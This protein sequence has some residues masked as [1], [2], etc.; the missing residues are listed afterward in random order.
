MTHNG[1]DVPGYR[2]VR[3]GASDEPVEAL[4]DVAAWTAREAYPKILSAG[5]PVFGIARERE[6][7]GWELHP[8][9]V[10]FQP[11]AARDALAM[12]LRQLATEARERGEHTGAAE[13]ERA[14]GRLDWEPL[15][16]VAVL[17]ERY[18]VVR[19]ERFIRSGPDGPEPPR[20]TDP[21]PAG[22]DDGVRTPDPAAGFVLD[23][24]RPTGMSEGILK[25][26][27]LGLTPVAGAV[28]ADV[29]RDALL[30]TASHPGG[31]LLPVGFMAAE[32]VDGRWEPVPPNHGNTPQQIRESLALGLRVIDPVTRGLDPDERAE[33]A[34]AAERWESERP[35]E[36]EVGGRRLRV[37]RV[38]RLVRFGPDGP[39]SPRPSDPD[40]ELPFLAQEELLCAQ[41]DF[42]RE[43]GDPFDPGEAVLEM[44]RLMREEEERRR[45]RRERG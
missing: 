30:V 37:V 15:N 41:G 22:P 24:V 3:I 33:Y 2:T 45:A 16:E 7:G 14:A 35:V 23:P 21:D 19:G 42:P 32:L 1:E 43:D 44:S 34:E 27:L 10:N 28:P 4:A 26:E 11:Q 40:T 6:Q 38:E 36:V 18:R 20:P 5:G 8:Y 9:F 31:V 12:T 25:V 13:Y 39:E 17:G 29:R